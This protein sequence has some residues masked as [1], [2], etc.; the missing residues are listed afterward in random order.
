R[1]PLV[2]AATPRI[3][4]NNLQEFVA[5]AKAAPEK[6]NYASTGLGSL[7]HLAPEQLKRMAGIDI[8]HVPF[9][10]GGP[11]MQ[12]VLGGVTHLT[13]LSYAALKSQIAAGAIKPLAVTGTA[14]IPDLP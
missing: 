1:F 8:L 10:G 14:R 2:I 12:S 5:A 3:A 6:F 13:F 7:N 4:A 9:S 11:A